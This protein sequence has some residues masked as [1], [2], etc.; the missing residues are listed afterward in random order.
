MRAAEK[1]LTFYALAEGLARRLRGLLRHLSEYHLG[2]FGEEGGGR[3]LVVAKMLEPR[4]EL[5][6]GIF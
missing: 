6:V 3:F 2:A 4:D 5:L 1:Q